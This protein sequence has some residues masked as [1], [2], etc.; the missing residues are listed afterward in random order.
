MFYSKAIQS[1]VLIRFAP[2]TIHLVYKQLTLGGDG[3]CGVLGARKG[4]SSHLYS[5]SH[6]AHIATAQRKQ[7]TPKKRL[8]ILSAF[9]NPIWPWSCPDAVDA[10]IQWDGTRAVRRFGV[11]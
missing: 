8:S 10:A 7:Q 11:P 6:S 4:C 2:E 3:L 9:V 1:K 5:H